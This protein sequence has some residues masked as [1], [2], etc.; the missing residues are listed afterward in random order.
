MPTFPGTVCLLSVYLLSL[1][2][3]HSLPLTST[4]LF[5]FLSFSLYLLC[6]GLL[7]ILTT[8]V[9]VQPGLLHWFLLHRYPL[10]FSF[11]LIRYLLV[12]ACLLSIS[13]Y[14]CDVIL[15]NLHTAL[16]AVA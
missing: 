1:Q 8:P 3:T 7:S 16:Y 2:I 12:L 10:L 4:L 14:M 15:L 13:E 6:P 11:S 9:C 5:L